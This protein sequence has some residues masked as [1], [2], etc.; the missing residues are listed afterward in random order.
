MFK[1]HA[2]RLFARNVTPKE[3]SATR[4]SR[5]IFS[6]CVLLLFVVRSDGTNVSV[7]YSSTQIV[8]AADTLFIRDDGR[9]GERSPICKLRN[10]GNVFFV[11]IGKVVDNPPTKFSLNALG[12]MATLKGKGVIGS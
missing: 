12:E 10:R 3:S 7:I 11:S 6:I 5:T 9:G 2:L 4:S 8:V 1:F